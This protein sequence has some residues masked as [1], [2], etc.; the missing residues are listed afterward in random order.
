MSYSDKKVNEL[1]QL[2]KDYGLPVTGT[3]ATLI[4]RLHQYEEKKTIEQNKILVEKN[5]F[6][7]F[8]KT[9]MGTI[10]TV[11]PNNTSTIGELKQLVE[12]ESG[13]PPEKQC[14][15]YIC[16]AKPK[17]G[18][19]SYPTTGQTGVQTENNKTLSDYNVYNESTFFLQMRLK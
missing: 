5:R 10:Y 15:Y 12:R 6:K 14:L 7:V 17:L 1:K 9:M 8:V 13:C 16:N 18:D 3:K 2:C 11:Y 19:I 4:D